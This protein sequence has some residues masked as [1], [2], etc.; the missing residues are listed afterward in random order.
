VFEEV[1]VVLGIVGVVVGGV[2]GRVLAHVFLYAAIA[3]L[4]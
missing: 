4:I 3:L 2:T 1:V